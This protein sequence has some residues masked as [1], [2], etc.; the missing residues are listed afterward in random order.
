[1]KR[2]PILLLML[3]ISLMIQSCKTLDS[4]DIVRLPPNP[5]KPVLTNDL[6][7]D[8]ITL[9][10]MYYRMVLWSFNARYMVGEITVEEY[11]EKKETILN[12]I[13]K[14]EKASS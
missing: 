4:V 14:I 3:L 6:K 5:S 7:E 12:I 8:N 2:K 13:S 10:V 11:E 1:M 9:V